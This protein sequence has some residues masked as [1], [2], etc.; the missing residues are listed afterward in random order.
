[1]LECNMKDT[2]ESTLSHQL[3]ELSLPES[4]SFVFSDRYQNHGYFH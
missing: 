3:I 4:H 2:D 1:M